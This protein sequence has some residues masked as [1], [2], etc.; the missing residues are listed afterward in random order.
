MD[1]SV[2]KCCICNDVFT[3]T[4]IELEPETV[5]FVCGHCLEKAKDNFI[6]LCLS[7]RKSFIRPKELVI[8]RVKDHELKKAYMLCQDLQII[9]GLDMCI[10]CDPER[11]IDYMEIQ[12]NGIE[13]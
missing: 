6:W 12:S 2:G 5:V 11:I 4:H 1:E 3:S 9:Q 10:A 8:N 13:C 7:C